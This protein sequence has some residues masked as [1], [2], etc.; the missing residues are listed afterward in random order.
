MS[1][2]RF[3]RFRGSEALGFPT[4][5]RILRPDQGSTVENICILEIGH[6]D[7]AH[8]GE[9][10]PYSSRIPAA[11]AKAEEWLARPAVLVST[12]RTGEVPPYLTATEVALASACYDLWYDSDRDDDVPIEAL[13]SFVEK[14]ESL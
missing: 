8:E 1:D 4:C 14:V 7:G 5:A 9:I 13:K 11:I 12:S 6:D 2:E 3:H 10:L